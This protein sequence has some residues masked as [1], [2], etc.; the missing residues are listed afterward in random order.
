[1]AQTDSVIPSHPLADLFPMLSL[2]DADALRLDI[3]ANGLRERIVI[4]DGQILDGRNRYRAAVGAG[5]IFGD[6]PDEASDLWVSHFRRFNPAQDGDPLAFVL[7]KNK[8]RRHLSPSQLAMLAAEIANLGVGRPRTDAEDGN[9]PP[10]GGISNE[11]A[12]DMVGAKLRNTERAAKVRDHGAPELVAA[13]KSG[14]VAVSAAADIAALPVGEQ[15][16][17]LQNRDPKAFRQAMRELRVRPRDNRVVMNTR[18]QPPDDLDYSPTPPWA[19]RSLLQIVLPHLGQS[20][21]GLTVLEPACGEGHISAVLEEAGPLAVWASDIWDYSVDGVSP[22]GWVGARD[23]LAD[24]EPSDGID[25]VV[26]N[27]PFGSKAERFA[28]RALGEAQV[29]V[30]MFVRLGWLASNG[31][32]ERLYSVNPP[33]LIAIFAEDVP[34]HMG[35][36]EPDG[37]TLSDYIWIVWVKGMAPQP[38]FWI[39]PGQRSALTL[40]DDIERFTAHPVRSRPERSAEVHA[41][42]ERIAMSFEEA[43]PILKA[44]YATTSGEELQRI[45]GRPIGT[46]RTWA[47]RLQLTS[48]A[49]LKGNAGHLGDKLKKPK[50]TAS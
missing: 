23:Y 49:R 36:W 30:A 29:G 31:R 3:A 11:A 22:P 9:I 5:V 44:R 39:P 42:S 32:Y 2:A 12:S 19:T 34:L 13:V 6:L 26:M 40:P 18:V 10:I 47:H 43:T 24:G 4:L 37:Q 7:S 16:A 38:P 15:L 20:L 48:A 28:H 8:F 21:S 25:W 35:R 45:T 17:L 41:M 1:M 14:E 27:S 46:I 33:T 50:E